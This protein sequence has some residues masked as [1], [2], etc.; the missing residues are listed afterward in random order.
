M[1]PDRLGKFWSRSTRLDLAKF[2]PTL[3]R[4]YTTLLWPNLT[5][6]NFIWVNSTDFGQISSEL[7][8]AKYDQILVVTYSTDIEKFHPMLTLSKTAKF[9]SGLTRPNLGRVQLDLIWSYLSQNILNLILPNIS[10]DKLY[11]NCQIFFVAASAKYDKFWLRLTQVNFARGR[12][13]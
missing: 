2:R 1:G 4:E 12:L 9:G 8:S 7:D 10:R 13:D 11:Q 3:T 6:P 5:Q